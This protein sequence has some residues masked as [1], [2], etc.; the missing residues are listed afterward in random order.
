MSAGGS[1]AAL[2]VTSGPLQGMEDS[3][4]DQSI[5]QT[6]QDKA[7]KG[8][9]EVKSF[10]P[11][12]EDLRF[13]G[14]G[15]PN[16]ALVKRLQ[17]LQEKFVGGEKRND[18]KLKEKRKARKNYAVSQREKLGKAAKKMENDGIMVKVYDIL[19]DDIKGKNNVINQMEGKLKSAQSEIDDLQTEF[20]RDREDYL[21]TIRKLEQIIKLLQQNLDKIQPCIRRDCN[22]YNIGKVLSESTW[23]KESGKWN[24]HELVITKT[25]LMP[26]ASNPAQFS[27]ERFNV[28]VFRLQP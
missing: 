21:E 9:Q 14:K 12:P 15:L 18:Q 10:I 24:I 28:N 1:N 3:S 16:D 4:K 23:D 25:A 5:L 11:G 13:L 6:V 20:E 8:V 7:I 19:Q 2:N 26:G 27:V 17:E 22:Y